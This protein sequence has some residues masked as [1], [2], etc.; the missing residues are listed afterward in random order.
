MEL[1]TKMKIN[2]TPNLIYSA[3]LDASKMSNFWFSDFKGEFKEGNEMILIYKEYNAEIKIKVTHI[4]EN[5]LIE[6]M[7]DDRTVTIR[8]ENINNETIVTAI[9]KHFIPEDIDNLLGQKEG[10]VY[11]LSC[12]KAYIEYDVS[13]RAALL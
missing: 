3:F 5:E 7:W 2:G 13:I 12:L 6:F 11:M 8:F 1:I 9:E 10:W 4:S